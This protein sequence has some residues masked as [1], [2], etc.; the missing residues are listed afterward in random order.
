MQIYHP[1]SMSSFFFPESSLNELANLLNQ[2]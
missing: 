1:S 2:L